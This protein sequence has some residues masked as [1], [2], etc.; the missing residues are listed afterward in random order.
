MRLARV[1]LNNFRCHRHLELELNDLTVLIGPNGS[2]KS[3]VLAALHWFFHDTPMVDEDAFL[4]ADVVNGSHNSSPTA[5]EESAPIEVTVEFADL[6]DADRSVLGRYGR[7][8]IATFKRSWT[9]RDGQKKYA[10]KI[11][12]NSLQ[13]PG[14]ANVRNG[15]SAPEVRSRYAEL[16]KQLIDLPTASSQQAVLEVLNQWE[17][18]ASNRLRLEPVANDDATHLFGFVGDAVLARRY[19]MVFV[20]ASVDLFAEVGETGRNSILTQLIGKVAT[21]AVN[22]AHVAWTERNKNS[23]SDL[24]ETVQTALHSATSVH[25]TRIN[26]HL[27]QFVPNA[28][29]TLRGERPELSLGRGA[30]VFTDVTIDDRLVSI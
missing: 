2:G 11:I 22:K 15:G 16:R 29:V 10:S 20:P 30:S 3:T 14:F 6:N 17:Q 26:E 1:T 7:G 19:Q 12:G 9:P 21:D 23:L 13:G 5:P 8:Q 24:E 4:V 18:I 28:Q 25:Q 27:S